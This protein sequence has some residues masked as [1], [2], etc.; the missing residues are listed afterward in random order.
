MKGITRVILFGEV[1]FESNDVNYEADDEKK[2]K[3]K[4]R[5]CPHCNGGICRNMCV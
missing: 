5:V 3:K 1:K 4:K 2:V